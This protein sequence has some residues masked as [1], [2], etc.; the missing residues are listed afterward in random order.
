MQIQGAEMAVI[1]NRRGRKRKSG[2]REP[3]GRNIRPPVDYR[4][5]AGLQPH[6]IGLP[7]ALR[8]SERAESVL[9]CLN[10]LKR[11]SEQEYEAGRRFGVIVGG[12]R[13]VIGTPRG[14]VGAGKGYNCEPSGCLVDA[15][16]CTCEQRTAKFRDSS[17]A[18]LLISQ[19]AYNA[20]YQVA[21]H[22]FPCNS[23]QLKHLQA[24]L[25][26]LANYYGLTSRRK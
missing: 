22:D 12:Y 7:A 11:I 3:S 9:G 1:R 25:R 8:E 19:K 20:V 10:L 23:E 4:A 21:V 13:S 18:L 14:T 17:R 2:R 5:M 16:N 6:R 24:G 26:G 15:T